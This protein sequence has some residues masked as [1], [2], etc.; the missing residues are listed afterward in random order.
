MLKTQLNRT[1]QNLVKTNADIVVGISGGE[2]MI[3]LL[4]FQIDPY[5]LKKC[6]FVLIDERIV[7]WDSIKCNL[8]NLESRDSKIN[9]IGPISEH[10]NL[11]VS[12]YQLYI[13]KMTN[14]PLD[15]LKLDLLILGFGK[16]GHIA[17][18]FNDSKNENLIYYSVNRKDN[19]KRMTLSMTV[20]Q[21][22]QNIYVI[23]NSK[24]KTELLTNLDDD[25]PI[26][27]L[28]KYNNSDKL[29]I[30]EI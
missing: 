5:I 7:Q 11:D 26:H 27:Q 30:F 3:K 24:E 8:R 23:S 28:I 10:Q 22:S 16:D 14:M 20:L 6:I 4:P 17:S 19:S 13:E 2:T 1:F 25:L 15:K 12:G 29:W 18:I 9:A 21:K